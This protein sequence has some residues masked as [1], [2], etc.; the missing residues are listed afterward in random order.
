MHDHHPIHLTHLILTC[1]KKIKNQNMTHQALL[2]SN[3]LKKPAIQQKKLYYKPA[4]N[5]ITTGP[6]IKITPLICEHHI[7]ILH[8]YQK[9]VFILHPTA[10]Y[11]AL[12]SLSSLYAYL[13]YLHHKNGIALILFIF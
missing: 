12:K 4:Q 10:T 6:A 1:N 9:K 7:C 3:I 11:F 8:L 13:N 5:I 2:C